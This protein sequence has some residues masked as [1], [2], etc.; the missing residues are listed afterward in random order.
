M[1]AVYKQIAPLNQRTFLYAAISRSIES[2]G[3]LAVT[4]IKNT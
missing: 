4:M 2:Y 3:R 1:C